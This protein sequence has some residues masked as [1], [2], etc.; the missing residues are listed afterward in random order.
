M[1]NYIVYHLHTEL[2]L[3]DS[4][5]NYKLYVDKA[6]ELGQTAICFSEHGNIYNWIEK[7]L[8]CKEKGIK[9]IHGVEI[10]LTE[11]LKENIRDNYHTI[12]IAK[13]YEGVKEINTLI[14]KSTQADH[15]YY[16]NRITFDEFLN[17]SD[18]VIKISACLA[19]PLNRL[20]EDNPYY[21]LL[22]RKYDYYEIQPHN[23][24]QQQEYNK[25]LLELSKKHGNQLI[26]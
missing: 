9:Y 3:L 17:I 25:K 14:D 7:K 24:N 5:T 6:V 1:I 2:S 10:Y 20:T 18:N 11:S 22:L 15:F 8:Y 26:I 13:N 12:L 4:S 21:D 19:S 16:K 23:Y